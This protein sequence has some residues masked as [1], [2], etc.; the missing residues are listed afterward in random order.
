MCLKIWGEKLFIGK[1]KTLSC[2]LTY[3]RAQLRYS[4]E[5]GVTL[6]EWVDR[7]SEIN[8]KL[9][10]FDKLVSY[11]DMESLSDDKVKDIIYQACP[12]AC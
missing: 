2:Q 12:Q 7:L 10:H 6:R 5:R 3:L 11:E 1:T 9:H 4:V 8:N